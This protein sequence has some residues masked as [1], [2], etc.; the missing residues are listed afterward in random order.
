[1]LRLLL[2]ASECCKMINIE[3]RKNRRSG[4]GR[5]K[6]NEEKSHERT[7]RQ[8]WE[9]EEEEEEEERG[10]WAVRR[11]KH[12]AS[13]LHISNIANLIENISLSSIG[14]TSFESQNI[15]GYKAAM[16]RR[17]CLFLRQILIVGR[18]KMRPNM[19][20]CTG[21]PTLGKENKIWQNPSIHEFKQCW[22]FH[23]K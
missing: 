11:S 6:E 14:K 4:S 18:D 1:M 9:E 16:L 15:R 5:E 10:N 7:G 2:S 3:E 13:L 17:K 22:R 20:N 21:P 23:V 19:T 12:R 8:A